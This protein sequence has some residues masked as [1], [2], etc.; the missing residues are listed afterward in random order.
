MVLFGLVFLLV[1][2]VIGVPVPFSFLL[3]AM[4]FLLTGDYEPTFMMPYGIKNLSNTVIFSIPLFIMA[5]KLMERGNIAEQLIGLVEGTVGRIKG[6]LGVVATVSCAVFGSVSGS[7][8]ATLTCIGGI[9]FPRLKKASYPRG[10]SAALLANACVLG[11]LIPPSGIMILYSWVG[12]QS[13]LASFLAT[14]VPGVLLTALFSIINCLLLRKNKDIYVPPMLPAEQRT[15]QKKLLKIW[16]AM[17]AIFMPV[18]VLGGIYSGIMTPTEAAAVAVMYAIPVGI[19]IY[20]G[21]T[22]QAIKETL[23][24]S[25]MATGTI[26]LM[27]LGCSILARMFVEEDLPGQILNFLYSISTNKYAILFMLNI[28]MVILGMLVDDTS[29]VLLATPIMIPII[30]EIGVSPVHFAAI[31]AVNSGMGNVTPPCAP[32]LYLSATISGTPVNETLKTT[33]WFLLFGWL[34]VLVLTTYVPELS[35]W[36]PKL[37]LGIR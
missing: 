27:M 9:M 3:T 23:K 2:L 8:A 10:H 37:V 30:R 22:L 24:D 1:S 7:A 32:L 29:A 35:M 6:G 21:L 11:M 5:G 19:F 12:G 28:F 16:V 14:V 26:M 25:G 4:Y 33:W 15:M 18:I 36:L 13:V 20:K 17:P 34:P 31:V